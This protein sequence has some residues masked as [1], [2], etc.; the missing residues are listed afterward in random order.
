[1][2]SP[3]INTSRLIAQTNEFLK[4]KKDSEKYCKLSQGMLNAAYKMEE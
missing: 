3:Q 1:M 2:K 4:T